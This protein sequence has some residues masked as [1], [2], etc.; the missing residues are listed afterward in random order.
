MLCDDWS[1]LLIWDSYVEFGG[2]ALLAVTTLGCERVVTSAPL[3]LRL[4]GRIHFQFILCDPVE[5]VG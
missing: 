4:A 5:R 2:A 3:S 1:I